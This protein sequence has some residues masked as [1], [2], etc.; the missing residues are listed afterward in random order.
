MALVNSMASPLPM[1]PVSRAGRRATN[2]ED[3]LVRLS[4]PLMTSARGFDLVQVGTVAGLYS[5]V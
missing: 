1:P 4:L 5:L 2:L 3:G